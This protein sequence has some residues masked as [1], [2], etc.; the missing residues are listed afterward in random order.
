M[1]DVVVVG[2]GAVGLYLARKFAEKNSSVLL[3]E[4]KEKIGQKPC[5]GLVSSKIFE[6]INKGEDDF[7]ENEFLK[8][9][10]WLEGNFFDFNGKALLLNR[11]KLDKYFF[12]KAKK[13]GVDIRLKKEVRKIEEKEAWVEILLESGEKIQGKI[14]AGCDGAVSTVAQNLNLP[15]QEKLLLGLIGYQFKNCQEDFKNNFPELFF[16]KNFPGFFAW[17]IPRTRNI[18]WGTA[19][20]PQQKPGEK[21]RKFLKE[22]KIEIEKIESALI[23]IFPR[24]RIVTKRCFLCGDAAGQIKPATGGGLIYG[25]LAAKMASIFIDPAKPQTFLYEKQWTKNL[26]RDIFWGGLLRKSY[27][28]PTFLKKIGLL[29]LKNKKNL[30]QDRPS[31]MFTP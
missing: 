17:R 19:L 16:S 8:A 5:S 23:P 10:I 21:L 31:T 26:Q 22:K 27:H 2:G 25:L 20:P 14:I 3:L 12:E 9:R 28:L 30:D 4:K 7:I 18:E 6:F 13:A 11:E 24:K 15:K 1:Y 29:W